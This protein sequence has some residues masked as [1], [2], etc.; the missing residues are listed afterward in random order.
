MAI[1]NVVVQ[2]MVRENRVE[3]PREETLKDLLLVEEE[4]GQK[5]RVDMLHNYGVALVRM[6]IRINIKIYYKNIF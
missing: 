2:K 1:S 3:E 4:E 6:K 5:V